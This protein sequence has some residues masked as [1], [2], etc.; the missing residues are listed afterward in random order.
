MIVPGQCWHPFRRKKLPQPE[1][2]QIKDHVKDS[3]IQKNSLRQIRDSS[4]KISQGRNY[5]VFYSVYL[6]WK[7]VVYQ[8]LLAVGL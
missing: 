7:I 8:T 3:S 5:L 6:P 4:Y 1:P 2:Q